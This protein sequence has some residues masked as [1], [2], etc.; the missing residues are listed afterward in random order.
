MLRSLYGKLAVVLGVILAVLGAVFALATVASSRAF[1]AEINQGLHRELAAHLVAESLPMSD[2]EVQ[3][4]LD[5][6]KDLRKMQ[7]R[8]ED[9][10]SQSTVE[11]AKYFQGMA[12]AAARGGAA[13]G[14]RVAH[15]GGHRYV[16]CTDCC[17]APLCCTSAD[18][19]PALEP[20]RSGLLR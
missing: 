16:L 20:E 14:D 10:V 17:I 11:Q 2:G 4:E 12:R 3:E 9:E 13:A 1:F 8:L 19:V 15:W 18:L 7:L 5:L 6:N